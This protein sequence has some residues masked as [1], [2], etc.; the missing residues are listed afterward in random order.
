MEAWYGKTEH[1]GRFSK[2]LLIRKGDF[3]PLFL[4]CSDP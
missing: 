1:V 2:L 3:G 4:N